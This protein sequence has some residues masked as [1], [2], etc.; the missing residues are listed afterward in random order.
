[1]IGILVFNGVSIVL[2]PIRFLGYIVQVGIKHIQRYREKSFSQM[3]REYLT[4]STRNLWRHMD[5]KFV[6]RVVDRFKKRKSL[7]MI[8]VRVCYKYMSFNL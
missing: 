8:P 5:Y 1:M 2:L 4:T 7:N 6:T 3:T